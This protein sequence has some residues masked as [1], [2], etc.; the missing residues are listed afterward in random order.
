MSNKT[1]AAKAGRRTPANEKAPGAGQRARGQRTTTPSY[2]FDALLKQTQGKRTTLAI[3]ADLHEHPP[4]AVR[5]LTTNR[6]ALKAIDLAEAIKARY[7]VL[8]GHL[9]NEGAGAI[10]VPIPDGTTASEQLPLAVLMVHGRLSEFSAGTLWTQLL[11]DEDRAGIASALNAG[12][13]A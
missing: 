12:G 8:G 2:D 11:T 10:A 4:A 5:R 13:A 1:N 3:A 7:I 6:D 9:M